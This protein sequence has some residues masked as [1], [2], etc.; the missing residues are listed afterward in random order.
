MVAPI[1]TPTIDIHVIPTESN[2]TACNV[3]CYAALANKHRGTMYT[4]ATGALPVVTLE[5]NQYFFVAYAYDP[6]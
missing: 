1:N 3:F 2:D 5:G 6:N 4:D